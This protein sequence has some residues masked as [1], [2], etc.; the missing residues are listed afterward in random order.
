MLNKYKTFIKNHPYVYI[1]LLMAF[2]SFIGISIEYIVNKDF[3]G[4]GIYSSLGITLIEILRVR[5]NK[6]KR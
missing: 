4:A 2:T 1:L 6:Q 5:K 3:I